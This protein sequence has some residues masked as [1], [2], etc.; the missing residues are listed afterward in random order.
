M[1]QHETAA[2]KAYD[3]V[4]KDMAKLQAD[5]D[6]AKDLKDKKSGELVGDDV[7]QAISDDYAQLNIDMAFESNPDMGNFQHD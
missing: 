2:M 3:V 1:N 4:S 6:R 5:L 7:R